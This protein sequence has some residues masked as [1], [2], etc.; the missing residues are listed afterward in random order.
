MV[1]QEQLLKEI[2][3]LS[4][5]IRMKNRAL[6]M[7][8]S[9]R[10][11]FLE[12]TFKPVVEPLREISQKLDIKPPVSEIKQ[13]I[14]VDENDESMDTDSPSLAE[15]EEDDVEVEGGEEGPQEEEVLKQA[16]SRLSTLGV[17]IASKGLLTRKYLVKMLYKTPGNRKVHVFGVRIDSNDGLMIGDSRL[18][19]DDSDNLVIKGKS[20]H[21]TPGLFELLFKQSPGKYTARDLNTYKL[22]CKLTNTHKLNYSS[23]SRVYRNK[24]DKYK[25]IISKIFPPRGADKTGKGMVMKNTYDTNVFYYNDINKLVD[26]LRLLHEAKKAGHTGLDSEMTTLSEELR[27]KGYIM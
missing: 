6:K 17:D 7:G 5:S 16:P 22:I 14:P 8:I 2:K 26:R 23:T 18:D 24:T 19:I 13:I 12:N 9:E 3:L 11:K 20:F 25:N 27:K 10:D 4:D 15:D 1:D 21:G